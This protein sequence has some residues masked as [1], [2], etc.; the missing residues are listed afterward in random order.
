MSFKFHRKKV[1]L[2]V[3][4]KYKKPR[5]VEILFPSQFIDGKAT[6]YDAFL[7]CARQY[8]DSET[9]AIERLKMLP[10]PVKEAQVLH[11]RITD[12]WRYKFGDPYDRLPEGTIV[13]GTN[14]LQSVNE[15]YKAVKIADQRL[16]DSQKLSYLK[17]L[18]DVDKH[19][20]AVFEMRPLANVSGSFRVSYE[21]SG[22]GPGNTTLDWQVKGR[23]INI[24]FDV[25]N[26]TKSLINHLS[27]II[28]HLNQ[29]E[30]YPQPPS[31][32]PADLFTSVQG[33]LNERCYLCQLQ[34]VWIHTDI[35]EDE[36]KLKH[37]FDNVLNKKKIHF[38]VISDW[39]DDA[40]ILACDRFI[41]EKLVNIFKLTQST[42]F[43]TQDYPQ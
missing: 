4:R 7:F 34:G 22:L 25:K 6:M 19:P 37:Y 5:K 31:P 28:P 20:D 39:Q 10:K 11:D 41:I 26:R 18:S 21:V 27:K 40:Y 32:D 2:W 35:K 36:L 14:I 1:G 33:K 9:R 23:I 43:V 24:V 15:L 29:G 8:G 42:R 30:D 13:S 3:P 17:R 38:A 12:L 16:T